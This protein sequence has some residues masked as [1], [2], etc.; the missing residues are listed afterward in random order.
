MKQVIKITRAKAPHKWRATFPD[1]RAVNF[2]LRGYSD[3]TI[4]KDQA[5]MK[6]YLTRHVKRENWSP[7]GRFKAGFW[8][9]WFLWS[10]PS[11]N[12]AARETE[13]VLGHKYRI[14]IS[15]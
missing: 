7:A 5:R 9:R 14:V 12:G 10:K 3:Y 1:G 6:R 15:R 8:S 13:R 4:H 2:G 11:L